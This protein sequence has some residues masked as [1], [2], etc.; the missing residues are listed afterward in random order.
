MDYLNVTIGSLFGEDLRTL[1]ELGLLPDNVDDVDVVEST[2]EQRVMKRKKAA[3]VWRGVEGD[4]AW[5]E[6]LIDGSR[7]G[8]SAKTRGG[9]SRNSDLTTRVEWEITEIVDQGSEL[10]A[11]A[12]G[13]KRKLDDIATVSDGHM[14]L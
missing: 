1:G 5:I 2:P 7:L 8:R 6:E 13:G 10:E 12:R 3:Q 4:T 11:D 9:V 14:Q